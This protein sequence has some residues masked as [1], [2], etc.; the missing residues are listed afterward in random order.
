[1]NDDGWVD[2]PHKKKVKK[3]KKPFTIEW[4]TKTGSWFKEWSLW[5]AYET[6]ANRDKAFKAISDKNDR[7][8]EYRKVER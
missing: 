3:V 6:E 8:F 1:M 2:T 5:K 4:K 7:W